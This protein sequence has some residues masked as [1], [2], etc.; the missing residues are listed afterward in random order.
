[1]D[2]DEFAAE[3]RRMAGNNGIH[4]LKEDQLLQVMSDDIAAGANF[5][6]IIPS[7]TDKNTFL[8]INRRSVI[9]GQDWHAR[10]EGSLVSTGRA[11]R[12]RS[13]N[14]EHVQRLHHRRTT[15]RNFPS[16]T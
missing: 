13:P 15:H 6:N 14:A 10:P 7:F 3:L 4:F 2:H 11:D 5:I 16:P 8:L 1:M 9:A 12:G